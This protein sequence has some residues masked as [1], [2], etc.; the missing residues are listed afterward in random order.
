SAARRQRQARAAEG[1]LRLPDDVRHV[2]QPSAGS[3][4]GPQRLRRR[5]LTRMDVLAKELPVRRVIAFCAAVVLTA[6]VI[7]SRM[8]AQ[9]QARPAGY[10]PTSID[11][12]LQA[13]RADLQAE[14]ADIIAKN[15]SLSAEQA[16]KF[17]PVYQEYQKQQDAIMDE[18]IRGIQRYIEA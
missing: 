16:A 4:G 15:V 1:L 6:A 17:W 12:V 2:R 18:Q 13:V 8:A 10:T 3:G 9:Q 7:T 11:E 14:R 5:G